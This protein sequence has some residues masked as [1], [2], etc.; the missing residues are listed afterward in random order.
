MSLTHVTRTVILTGAN[1]GRTIQ[2]GRYSFFEGR[3]KLIGPPSEVDSACVYIERMW[4]GYPEGHPLLE[5]E[6]GKRNLQE[7]TERNKQHALL[8]GVQPGGSGSGETSTDVSSQPGQGAP[9]T[10]AQLAAG[11]GSAPDVNSKLLAAVRSLDP[12]EETHW[13]QD[14]K[15]AIVAIQNIYGQ[16]GFTR[17]DVDAVLP[18]YTRAAAHEALKAEESGD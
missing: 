1:A 16:T 12:N 14:G 18:G 7:A 10:A 3:T 6:D 2:L 15:P 9:R 13:T 17:K 11:D 4:E 5:S 8:S